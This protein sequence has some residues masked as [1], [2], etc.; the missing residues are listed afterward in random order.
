LQ[1]G[2]TCLSQEYPEELDSGG[3]THI[4]ER[5]GRV[6]LLLEKLMAKISQHDEEDSAAKIRTPQSIIENNELPPYPAP[7]ND[8][9]SI[10]SLYENPMVRPDVLLVLLR[11]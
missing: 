2:T 5:L 4:G 6:E 1:R 7:S 9:T 8:I 10:L 3:G 11:S